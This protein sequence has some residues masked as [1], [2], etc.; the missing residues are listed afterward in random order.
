MAR[1]RNPGSGVV[2]RRKKN[3]GGKKRLRHRDLEDL[4]HAVSERSQKKRKADKESQQSEKSASESSC[5]RVECDDVD[6]FKITAKVVRP[7]ALTQLLFL[8][9]SE[10]P[11]ASSL[12]DDGVLTEKVQRTGG[13]GATQ[14]DSLSP[15]SHATASQKSALLPST[16]S[17]QCSQ[18]D[19][20]SGHSENMR[21]GNP[22]VDSSLVDHCGSA[23]SALNCTAE[24]DDDE[25]ATESE[26]EGDKSEDCDGVSEGSNVSHSE[27]EAED[28][29]ADE[30]TAEETLLA[31]LLPGAEGYGTSA[32]LSTVTAG[33]TVSSEF[34]FPSFNAPL[35]EAQFLVTDAVELRPPGFSSYRIV[36]KEGTNTTNMDHLQ[37][38]VASLSSGPLP[39]LAAGRDAI[40]E[41]SAGTAEYPSSLTKN[42]GPETRCKLLRNWDSFV[43]PRLQRAER[44]WSPSRTLAERR[45]CEER[46][47]TFFN[48]M[49]HYLDVYHADE[50]YPHAATLRALAML[51]V[52]SH[53]CSVRRTLLSHNVAL[54]RQIAQE[55]A[56][57]E[58]CASRCN[59]SKSQKRRAPRTLSQSQETPQV[60]EDAA[61]ALRMEDTRDDT[62][63]DQGFTQPRVLILAP[64]RC[65]AKE[66][67]DTLLTLLPRVKQVRHRKRFE[68]EFGPEEEEPSNKKRTDEDDDVTGAA[69]LAD[70][71]P[72][73]YAELF[74]GNTS[75]NFRLGIRLHTS[76]VTLYTP[77]YNSDILVCSPLGLQLVV[78]SPDTG[79][80]DYDFLSSIELAIVDRADVL[81]MQNWAHV[82]HLFRVMN[83]KPQ[84]WR[85]DCDIRRLR[86]TY[87]NGEARRFRQT[88]VLS[89]GRRAECMALFSS[90][91]LTVPPLCDNF[92]G[93]IK[94]F[95]NA[96]GTVAQKGSL[97]VAKQLLMSVP[98]K[99]YADIHEATLN[100]FASQF[101]PPFL[102][103]T[104]PSPT[105]T[106]GDRLLLVVPS[107]V[108]YLRVRRVLK[109]SNNL[110]ADP[111][112]L[113]TFRACHEYSSNKM[114]ST[115]RH[116]FRTGQVNLL[117][118][119]ERFLFYRRYFLKGAD[120]VIFYQ[121]LEYPA[122]Y[123]HC[124]EALNQPARAIALTLFTSFHALQCERYL[125]PT[126]TAALLQNLPDIPKV[127]VLEDNVSNK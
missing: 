63:R 62:F 59:T 113:R 99:S 112:D 64:T 122:L 92:R 51:H 74:R 109:T 35:P 127:F 13:G 4:Y 19:D 29:Q 83:V 100:F 78:G 48:L 16:C 110:A 76:G 34:T 17:Q 98:C 106:S 89:E 117:I 36:A 38:F 18:A 108:E 118:T 79:K 94:L 57:R 44:R 54:K 10:D 67:V 1:V 56:N 3:L 102:A 125:G 9:N 85:S 68:A 120:H 43:A 116:M 42:D 65:I 14:A 123:L 96:D 119:T 11:D 53:L 103:P 126:R 39:W 77:F 107:Y 41:P 46:Y 124:L 60:S 87:A 47:A 40:C 97:R 45:Q 32:G 73:D 82:Q 66:M 23:D 75:D 5:A 2:G 81:K 7:S 8:L 31:H 27:E 12:C 6:P 72:A 52:A 15:L 84:E 95:S 55:Q 70:G 111:R 121:P 37:Q 115:S 58:Q 69:L 61:T 105:P 26:D 86:Q 25:L 90:S 104:H 30:D 21:V 91:S 49:A 20:S 33:S 114:L 28:N 50:S 71:K 88:I 93:F 24:S 22:G 101:P 80:T